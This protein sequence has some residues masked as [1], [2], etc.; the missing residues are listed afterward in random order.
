MLSQLYIENVAV[1][2]RASIDLREGLNVFTGETGAGKTM[3]VWAIGAVLGGRVSREMIRTGESKAVVS[4]LFTQID[5]AVAARLEE[6]GC[7]LDEGQLLVSREFSLDGRGSCRIN[8]RPSTVSILRQAAGMLIQIHGQQDNQ[9]LADPQRHLRYLDD[10]G[11]H[12]EALAEYRS[13]YRAWR[14]LQSQLDS[15][16]MDEAEK[17]RRM[18]M[19]AFQVQELEEARLEAG[20]E[21]ELA[22]QRTRIRNAEKI[23]SALAGAKTVL[24]GTDEAEGVLSLLDTLRDNLNAA[25]RYLEELEEPSQRAEGI[26]YELEELSS[27]LGELLESSE[28]DPRQLGEIEDRLDLLYR[29]KRKYGA[30]VEEMLAYLEKSRRE[31]EEL[32]DSDARLDRLAGEVEEALRRTEEAGRK[33]SALRKTAAREFLRQVQEELAFLDMPQVKLSLA[34]REK[35]P[36]PDGMDQ[37]ELLI[38]TNPGEAPKPLAKIASGG[39]MSRLM[40]AVKNVMAGREEIATMIFDEIDTGVSGRAAQKIGLKLRQAAQTRQVI[41]VTHLAQVAAYGHHQ[42]KIHKEVE[43]GKTF[44]QVDPLT[45]EERV[46]ELARMVGGENLTPTALQNADEMLR[47][48]GN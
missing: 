11:G 18:D 19:L 21:E 35:A 8:G 25:G 31:L 41:C 24:E 32:Q 47:L 3:L 48:A 4:A 14:D 7:P 33:L 23:T 9:E 20:E 1:I 29:L 26:Y 34:A 42:L 15:L 46:Q 43:A 17:A 12:R 30:T 40:L 37:M 38:V 36:G 16:Q 6:L 5:P 10:F 28:F 44:T 22:A 2:R 27:T 45:R 13:A 39:E